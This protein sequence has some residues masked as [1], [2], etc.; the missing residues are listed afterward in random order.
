M[1]C[2]SLFLAT[3]IEKMDHWWRTIAH[4]DNLIY[5]PTQRSTFL[6]FKTTIWLFI[7]RIVPI[8]HP[9]YSLCVFT[10]RVISSNRTIHTNHHQGQTI[11][12]YDNLICET[13]QRSTFLVFKTWI[14]WIIRHIVSIHRPVS[15]LCIC[16][17]TV[18][19]S[20]STTFWKA[21]SY[22]LFMNNC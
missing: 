7:R 13:S 6:P 4:H 18:T 12:Y 19:D 3:K 16:T 21:K 20:H 22:F 15:S 1:N 5:E 2:T 17:L 9:V 8:R 14:W 11:A 10:S